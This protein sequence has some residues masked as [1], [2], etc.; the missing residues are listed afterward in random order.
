MRITSATNG[1]TIYPVLNEAIAA[2]A[3]TPFFT[4]ADFSLLD[5][6]CAILGSFAFDHL[7]RL[8]IGGLTADY[9]L[10]E[11]I[12]LPAPTTISSALRSFVASLNFSSERFASRWNSFN[13]NKDKPWRM[14]WAH[15]ESERYRLKIILDSL[16]GKIYGLDIND[17][18]LL[19]RD[20]DH[21][22]SSVRSD[23][24]TRALD[25]KG[26]W[27]VDK[28]KDPE[29]RHTVLAQ[30]AFQDLQSMGLDAFLAQNNGECWMLPETLRL[31]DYGLGH[32]DRAQQP[33]PVASRFGPRFY[34]WQ[35]EG[36]VEESWEECRRH[37]ALIEAIRSHGR[38]PDDDL[39]TSKPRGRKKK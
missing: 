31:S 30:V 16:I 38:S 6:L 23:E 8:R 7:A 5:N 15:T 3:N 26:F 20:C 33:Q 39:P 32:D 9:H 12:A 25:P 21:P 22:S 18:L 28:T 17:Y 19:L 29:L 24:F 2:E 10:M 27:R 4:P 11:Q 13:G 36:T 1:R 35:L 37:A 34:D 14:L